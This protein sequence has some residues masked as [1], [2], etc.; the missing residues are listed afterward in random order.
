MDLAFKLV[1]AAK[2]A[3]ADAVKFQT[4]KAENVVI[5]RGKMVGYQIKNIGQEK[6]Q[7]EMI[8][9]IELKDKDFGKINEYCKKKEIIFLST[10][11]G[12]K[13]SVDMLASLRMPA[14]KIASGDLTNYIMLEKIAKLGKPVILS[15]GMATLKEIRNTVAYLQSKGNDQII[16]LQCTTSYPCPADEANVR[17]MLTIAQKVNVLVG[18]SDHTLGNEAA[19]AATTL[20]AMMYECHFTLDKKLPGPDH[21]A[22]AS[23]QELKSRIKAIRITEKILG[24]WQK[25]PTKSETGEM[26]ETMRKSVVAAHRMKKGHIISTND[27]EAKRPGDGLSPVYFEKLIGLVLKRNIKKNEQLLISHF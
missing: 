18:Y 4:F 7:L 3:G 13:Q 16:V 14:Y 17:S 2:E 5:P 23:P 24:N 6:S 12:G 8:R 9:K 19:I 20:G 22:S 21:I 27:L 15:T 10:P 25:E 1:D 26:L 11:H